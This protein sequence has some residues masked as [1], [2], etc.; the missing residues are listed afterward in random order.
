MVLPVRTCLT[1]FMYHSFSS[2]QQMPGW[3]D[4][5]TDK[6]SQC[7]LTKRLVRQVKFQ[8]TVVVAVMRWFT[9]LLVLVLVLGTDET[10]VTYPY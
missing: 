4:S 3:S 2:H 7:Y 6:L 1:T 10:A 8:V 5:D 9:C